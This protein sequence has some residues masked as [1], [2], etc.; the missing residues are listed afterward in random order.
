M[1]YEFKRKNNKVQ[2]IDTDK[3]NTPLTAAQAKRLGRALL[4]NAKQMKRAHRLWRLM[5]RPIGGG[6]G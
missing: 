3:D 6:G 2:L 4:G 1:R 5:R